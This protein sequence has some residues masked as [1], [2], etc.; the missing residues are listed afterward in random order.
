MSALG[1]V[2]VVPEPGLR[3]RLS[4]ELVALGLV[5]ILTVAVILPPFIPPFSIGGSPAETTPSPP[6]A[7]ASTRPEPRFDTASI[8][9]LLEINRLI[10]QSRAP[11]REALAKNT[12]D[13]AEVRSELSRIVLNVRAGLDA[14]TRLQSRSD[15]RSVGKRVAKYYQDLR[16][17]ADRSFAAALANVVVHRRAA[18]DMVS[19]L[20]RRAE[21]DDLLA[22]LLARSEAPPSSAP[23]ATAVPSS[24][25]TVAPSATAP[26]PVSA[27]SAV[28]GDVIVN[29]GFE[30]GASP[31]EIVLRDTAALATGSVDKVQRRFGSASLRVDITTSSESRAG[32]AVV[33]PGLRI[34]S[35]R[36]VIRLF[37]RAQAARQIRVA[38]NNSADWTYG[39]R[40]FDIG[41]SWTALEF[42]LT[43]IADDDS[44]SLE[45]GLGRSSATVWLDGIVVA[46]AG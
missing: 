22:N 3:E 11:L 24:D 35:G 45:V 32:I 16:A 9:L 7:L 23:P 38:V 40:V 27:A 5:M 4:P 17:I 42:E 8:R 18:Q 36:Y 26:A 37:A 13:S 25:L 30:S 46:P 44:A 43:A 10:G 1:R 6:S 15:T 31:W 14:T 34:H 20:A 41:P 33:E 29:G 21:I 12:L 19:A 2:P 39:E 28:P